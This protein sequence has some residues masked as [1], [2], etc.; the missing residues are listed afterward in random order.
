MISKPIQD[1]EKELK[2]AEL[3]VHAAKLRLENPQEDIRTTTRKQIPLRMSL[4]QYFM[5]TEIKKYLGE[6]TDTKAITRS[7]EDYLHHKKIIRDQS[8]FISQQDIKIQHLESKIAAA[9]DAA[10]A[11]LDKTSQEEL[12]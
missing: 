11:L 6:K 3:E 7:I 10:L 4:H 12:I 5:L 8:E 9:R 2:K 1:L